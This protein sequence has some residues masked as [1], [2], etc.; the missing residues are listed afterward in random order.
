MRATAEARG[1]VVIT[2]AVFTAAFLYQFAS[3]R[4][5]NDHCDHLSKAVHVLHGEYPVRDFSTLAVP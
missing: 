1:H 3:V 5:S 2:M 4:F